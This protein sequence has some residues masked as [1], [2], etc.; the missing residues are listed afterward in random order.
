MLDELE[1]GRLGPLDVVELDHQWLPTRQRLQQ[2]AHAP[3]QLFLRCRVDIETYGL[4]DSQGDQ[5]ALA[6]GS[7]Q[8]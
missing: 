1:E 7:Y 6:I 8:G 2:L 5:L 3:E 4:G